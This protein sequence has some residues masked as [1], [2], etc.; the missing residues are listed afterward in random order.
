LQDRLNA[1]LRSEHVQMLRFALPATS[2]VEAARKS[3][4]REIAEEDAHVHLAW[5]GAP[6]RDDADRERVRLHLAAAKQSPRTRDAAYL[7]AAM[8]L[9]LRDDLDGAAREVAEGLRDAHDSAPF[10][11]AQ[12]DIL[13][14][15]KPTAA[16]LKQG[17]DRLR[18]VAKTGGQLC[19]LATVAALMGDRQAALQLGA[20]ATQ[21]APRLAYCRPEAIAQR[22]SQ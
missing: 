13:L 19:T 7:I 4:V 17:A 2:A 8:A 9:Y 20:R 12:L 15:G 21:L 14:R 6:Y 18:P 3:H 16:E 11:E 1:F 5:L 22:M 10:L